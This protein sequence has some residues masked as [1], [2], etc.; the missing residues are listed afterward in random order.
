MCKQ[1][2]TVVELKHRTAGTSCS[3]RYLHDDVLHL[4]SIRTTSS[5]P[6]PTVAGKTL[7][8]KP[9]PGSIINIT[10][11]NLAFMRTPFIAILAV[12]YFQW[13]A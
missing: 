3:P 1:L 7:P 10:V 4:Q 13:L 12:R 11:Q 5:G 9:S 2:S 6:D 8:R